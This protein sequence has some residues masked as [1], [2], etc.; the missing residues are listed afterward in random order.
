[1]IPIRSCKLTLFPLSDS[2]VIIGALFSLVRV[3]FFLVEDLLDPVCIDMKEELDYEE[4]ILL[5]SEVRLEFSNPG[6]E[7]AS[8]LLMFQY[9]A[10]NL[11]G[12]YCPLRVS[13]TPISA[14]FRITLMLYIS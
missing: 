7:L 10:L 5:D 3:L 1:M 8:R 13:V 11:L 9:P 12:S 2:N 6:L 4:D 14:L